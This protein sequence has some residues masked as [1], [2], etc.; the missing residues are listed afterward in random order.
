MELLSNTIHGEYYDSKLTNT[1]VE[2]MIMLIKAHT[3]KTMRSTCVDVIHA[4][5]IRK[6]SNVRVDLVPSLVESLMQVVDVVK[7]RP[8]AKILAIFIHL[9]KD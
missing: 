9:N 8:T 6:E 2:A 4:L 3:K 1:V 5:I 7:S